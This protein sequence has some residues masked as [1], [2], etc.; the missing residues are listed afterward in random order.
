MDVIVIGGGLAGLAATQHLTRAGKTVL[1]LE[2]RDRLGGRVLT[3]RIPGLS[4]PIE[5]G[6]EWIDPSS[7]IAELLKEAGAPII[8]AEGARYR[9]AGN[10]LE[11]LDDLNRVSE[12]LID[13]MQE[14]SGGDR[15]LIE[16]LDHCCSDP[17]FADSRAQLL[18][19][20][21][22]FHAADPSRVSVEWL[23]RVEQNQPADASAHHSAQGVDRVLEALMPATDDGVVLQ[24]NTVVREIEWSR[25]GVSV[26]AHR[27]GDH[28]YRASQ[29]I[30]TLPLGVIQS[31]RVRFRPTLA[32]RKPSLSLLEMGQVVKVVLR[33]SRPFWEEL[34][35]L[36]DMLF[37]HAFDQPFPTWWTTRPNKT[38]LITG[39]TAGPQLRGLGDIGSEDLITP[40]LHSLAAALDVPTDQVARYLEGW[41]CHDW[42]TDPFA[43][44]A[45]S[46]VLA[47]G[48]D[49]W[50]NLAEPLDGSLYFAGEATASEGYNAT[51]EGAL[52]S[53][54]RAA[55][56]IL[57]S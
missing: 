42:R 37:L 43:E 51:M 24:L 56:E 20:V 6:P 57:E 39:W 55:R 17:R 8:E 28:V 29:A 16:A 38:A 45:Y 3:Q 32:T 12:N 10:Q 4:H 49:A 23:A 40:A 35:S 19:Y 33:M 46:W 26:V 14:L 34:P 5:L 53:G 54:T 48:L 11:N 1:L 31:G 7:S 52:L 9:R 25:D 15:P 18:A 2:A 41:Y 21:E 27:E 50:R 36:K 22:G 13:R 47:G 44:G 30:C